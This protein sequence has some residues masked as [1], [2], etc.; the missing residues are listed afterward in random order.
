MNTLSIQRPRP[1]IE[2]LIPAAP[3]VSVKAALVNCEPW[4]VLKISGRP[5]RASASSRASTQKLV[6]RVFD[7]RRDSTARLAQSMIATRYR[8]PRPIGMYVT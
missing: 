8:N 5:N 4:S 2:I 7:S 6:S 3:S 1:S